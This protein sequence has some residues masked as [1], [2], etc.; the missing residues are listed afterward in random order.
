[1]R[2]LCTCYVVKY[3]YRGEGGD[4]GRGGRA[5]GEHLALA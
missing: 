4:E 5:V 3:D 2:N 1:M